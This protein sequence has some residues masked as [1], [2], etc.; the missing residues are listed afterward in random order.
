MRCHIILS[1]LFGGRK[2][3]RRGPKS[4]HARPLCAKSRTCPHQARSLQDTA[5]FG[6]SQGF[7]ESECRRLVEFNIRFAG[8]ESSRC[9]HSEISPPRSYSVIISPGCA[10]LDSMQGRNH[11]INVDIMYNGR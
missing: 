2:V 10:Q 9:S 4:A 1:K 3:G 8:V 6:P 7:K 11:E 5:S